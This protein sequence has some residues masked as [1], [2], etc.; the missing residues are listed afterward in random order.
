[1]VTA[2]VVDALADKANQ[3]FKIAGCKYVVACGTDVP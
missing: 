1:M 3:V 2:K